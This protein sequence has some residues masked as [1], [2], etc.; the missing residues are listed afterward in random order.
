MNASD[1]IPYII[2]Q[3][4][5]V[6]SVLDELTLLRTA[7]RLYAQEGY[8]AQDAVARACEMLSYS[9]TKTGNP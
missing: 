4:T 6:G 9:I 1:D 7:L 8:S 5:C 2:D 3:L